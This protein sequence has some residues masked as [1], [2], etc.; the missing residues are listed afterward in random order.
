VY[1][2]GREVILVRDP[3]DVVCS[4]NAFNTLRG[5]A[6]FGRGEQETDERFV[7]RMRPKVL[8]L[9]SGYRRREDSALL[10]RY[11]DLVADPAQALGRLLAGLDVDAS[12]AVI[13]RMLAAAAATAELEGHRTTPAADASIGR[14]K[15]DL[16]PRLQDLCIDAFAE[17][18]AAFGYC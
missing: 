3:C 7:R 15:H 12:A 8:S 5:Y 13:R 16:S 17:A 6:A 9:L 1:P 11:E 18:R 14:W 10:L 2:S 4:M